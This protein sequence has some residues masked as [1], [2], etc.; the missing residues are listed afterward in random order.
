MLTEKKW[1]DQCERE[2]E[3]WHKSA[4]DIGKLEDLINKF[5]IGMAGD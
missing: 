2:Y 1:R 4:V 3:R 5:K